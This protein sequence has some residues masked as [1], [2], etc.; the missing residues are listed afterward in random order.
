MQYSTAKI[1][2]EISINGIE[3]DRGSVY[4]RLCQLT[5]LR[6]VNG[7]RYR[8]ETVLRIVIIAKRRLVDLAKTV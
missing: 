1:E 8:L 2:R 7:R 4:D 6:G 5:D 3:F